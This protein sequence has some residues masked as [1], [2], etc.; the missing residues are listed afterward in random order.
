[1]TST[2]EAYSAAVR[3]FDAR[4][5]NG[6]GLYIRTEIGTVG[7]LGGR[8]SVKALRHLNA[9]GWTAVSDDRATWHAT[10]DLLRY[11]TSCA[12]SDRIWQVQF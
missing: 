4:D 3:F 6:D 7:K 9:N 1:M 10:A 2:Q 12:A 8:L 5:G 11:A